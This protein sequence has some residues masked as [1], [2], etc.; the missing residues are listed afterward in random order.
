MIFFKESASEPPDFEEFREN[1]R[2]AEIRST[3]LNRGMYV[4]FRGEKTYIAPNA[5]TM[6]VDEINCLLTKHMAAVMAKTLNAKPIEKG[7]APVNFNIN[8]PSILIPFY[9]NN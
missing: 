2:S 5:P 4:H 9:F 6:T 1:V 7:K 3:H 8:Y